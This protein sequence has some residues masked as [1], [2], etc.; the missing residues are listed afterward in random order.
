MEGEICDEL[1][2]H[3]IGKGIEE[4]R[5]LFIG[6]YWKFPEQL[7]VVKEAEGKEKLGKVGIR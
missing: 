2:N 3:V 1:D 5:Y 7:Q 4:D 6:R